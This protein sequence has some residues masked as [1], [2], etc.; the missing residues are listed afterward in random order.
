MGHD[1]TYAKST[2]AE[3]LNV[4]KQSAL[5]PPSQRYHHVVLEDTSNMNLRF[6][7]LSVATNLH[8]LQTDG[9]F[10]I[11]C[12]HEITCRSDTTSESIEKHLVRT[13]CRELKSKAPGILH[14]QHVLLPINL[15]ASATNFAGVH[16][17]LAVFKHL[18]VISY[19]QV[20]CDAWCFK[21]A[22]YFA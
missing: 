2:V 6:F 11:Y 10:A 16:W 1:L 8:G 9:K 20:F 18:K 12:Q 19:S 21:S 3:Q 15:G 5:N 14:Q 4:P 13:W 7:T 22:H 17:A